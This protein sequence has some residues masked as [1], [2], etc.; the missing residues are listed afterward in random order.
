MIKI[1]YAFL[2]YLFLTYL[3]DFLTCVSVSMRLVA[4]SNRLGLDRYLFSRKC[5]NRCTSLKNMYIVIAN[6]I[7]CFSTQFIPNLHTSH[8]RLCQ[9]KTRHHLKSLGPGQVLVLPETFQSLYQ[10]QKCVCSMFSMIMISYAFS[11]YIF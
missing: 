11:S 1:S 5:F 2:T 7:I 6:D 3:F 9:H 10:T 8:L 4:T